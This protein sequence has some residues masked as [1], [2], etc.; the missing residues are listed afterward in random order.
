EQVARSLD[1]FERKIQ[2]LDRGGW[3]DELQKKRRAL[4]RLLPTIRAASDSLLRDLYVSRAAEKTGI[5]KE[6]LLRE[7]EGAPREVVGRLPEQRA[8]PSRRVNESAH[9]THSAPGSG[10]ERELVRAILADPHRATGIAEKVDPAQ[11]QNQHYRAIFTAMLLLQDDFNVERL[12]DRLSGEDVDILNVL[13]EEVGAQI[14][15][16]RTINDSISVIAARPGDA[17]REEIDALFSV[18]SEEEI[19]ELTSEKTRLRKEI[20]EQPFSRGM[21]FPPRRRAPGQ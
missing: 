16:E 17:R 9:R 6:V 4:D 2:I 3:F 19:T 8:V 15:P 5:A 18:A 10:A 11:F 13:F 7:A 1:V 12:A 20:A 14:N 21:K